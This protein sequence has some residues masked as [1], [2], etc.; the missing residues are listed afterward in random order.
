[1]FIKNK[2]RAIQDHI[3]DT[4]VVKLIDINSKD[5]EVSKNIKP[6]KSH[7]NYSLPGEIKEGALEEIDE[8]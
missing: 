5:K 3:S 1:M 2:H 4:A 7:H 6:K 8:L